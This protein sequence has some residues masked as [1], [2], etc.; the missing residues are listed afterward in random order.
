MTE[1]PAR[2]TCRLVLVCMAPKRNCKALR[3]AS[4]L[5]TP[6]MGAPL[7]GASL[8][9]CSHTL[10]TEEN[11]TERTETRQDTSPRASSASPRP[12]TAWEMHTPWVT[13][14][15]ACTGSTPRAPLVLN[16]FWPGQS[17]GG[18]G[19]ARPGSCHS[20]QVC[21]VGQRQWLSSQGPPWCRHKGKKHG[22]LD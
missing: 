7:M 14:L 21:T 9:G 2:R 4:K 19:G 18:W 22:L 6:L 15:M 13:P 3:A 17:S 5:G 11:T 16:I 10:P 8:T 12:V 20:C 1:L